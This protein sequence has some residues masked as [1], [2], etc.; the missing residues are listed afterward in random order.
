MLSAIFFTLLGLALLI[1]GGEALIKGAVNV[2]RHFRIPASII[3]LTVVAYGTSAPELVVSLQA[4]AS[5]SPDIALGNV[6]GSNISNLW[7]VLGTT[8]LILPLVACRNLIR[9]DGL[10]MLGVTAILVGLCYDGTLSH[11]D[12][13]ILLGLLAAYTAYCL[14]TALYHRTS[15]SPIEALEM[16]D[17]PQ[18]V[19]RAVIFILLGLILLTT[20]ANFLVDGASSIARGFGVSEAVIGVTIVALGTSAPEL[21]ASIMAALRKHNDVAVANIIGSN[22]FNMVGILGITA[23]I[24]PIPVAQQFILVDEW[25]MLGATGLALAFLWTGARLSRRE[26]GLFVALYLSYVIYQYTFI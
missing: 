21:F 10:M 26:G 12:G 15:E 6:I 9:R 1:G 2:A 16:E 24:I 8:A 4:A 14:R 3:G 13:L 20:G 25:V 23:S 19:W 5:G 7:L 18:P 17:T 22:M 11:W